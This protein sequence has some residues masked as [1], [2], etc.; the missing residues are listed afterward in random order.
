MLDKLA[1]LFFFLPKHQGEKPKK[2]IEPLSEEDFAKN[3]E[4]FNLLEEQI[5]QEEK[6]QIT[7]ILKEATVDSSRIIEYKGEDLQKF[8]FRPETWEQFVGQKE[9][10]ERAKTIMKKAKK[11]IKAHFLV[12]GIKG[13]GKTTFVE[14]LAK[15]L[16]AHIIKRIGKQVDED[17][18]IDILNEINKST[19]KHV[20]LFIDEIDTMEWK[21]IKILNPIIESFEL[22]GKRIKPFIFAGATINK[23]VLIKNNP[24]T[25]DRIPTHI[26]FVRYNKEELQHILVQYCHEL[27]KGEIV[28]MKVFE[29]LA[30]N[31]KFNPRTGLGLLE[32]YIVEGDLKKVLQNCHILKYGLTQLD[33]KLLTVL[34]ESKRAMGANALA[35]KS[36]LSEH[37]YLREYEPFLVEYDYINRIPSRVITEKG[38][39]ILANLERN[40]HD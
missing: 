25:L 39:N 3:Q 23:H 8:E 9:A 35:M 19:A 37:E 7:A 12:D 33:V 16:D 31:C 17:N 15:S 14:L 11:G 10:K 1:R 13:H 32:E 40:K 5:K 28:P 34:S 36:G 18:I 38:R 26:K 29:G 2:G 22:E 27:Y 24:D 4:N 20:I 30:E 21:I 6:Q